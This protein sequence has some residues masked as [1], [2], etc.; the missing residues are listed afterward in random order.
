MPTFQDDERENQTRSLF[1]LDKVPG[2]AS[3]D[4]VLRLT[5]NI[6]VEF[7][8]KSTSDAS[9]SVTTARDFGPDHILKWRKKHWLFSFY[10][11]ESSV[12][13]FHLY[14]SPKMMEQWIEEKW[15]YVKPDFDSA[16]LVANRLTVDDMFAILS[17]KESYSLEDA[18]KLHKRQWKVKDYES[19]M[20]LPNAYSQKQMLKIYA[21]R[22]KY[23]ISRGS[24]LNNP[25]IPGTYFK[26]WKTIITED[27]PSR[28][29]TYV[30]ESLRSSL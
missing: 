17:K 24:T 29:R 14:G 18:R 19:R 28:L 27:H 30:T 2:R 12:A 16:T 20:D 4:A 26:D 6:E 22:I 1:N 7:E 15:Q 3:T 9:R 23:L 21:E 8:L 10:E 5:S 13:K 11:E 25:H